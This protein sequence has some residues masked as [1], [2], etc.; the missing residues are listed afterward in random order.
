MV[1]CGELAMPTH[2]G[3]VDFTGFFRPPLFRELAIS[4]CSR[5]YSQNVADAKPKPLICLDA[6]GA[7]LAPKIQIMLHPMDNRRVNPMEKLWVNPRN[8]HFPCVVWLGRYP[9]DH[10]KLFSM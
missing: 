7:K 4:G 9:F 5:R 10:L 6:E 3:F 1:T 2:R 8:D